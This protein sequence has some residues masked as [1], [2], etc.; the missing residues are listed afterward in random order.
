[1]WISQGEWNE[2]TLKAIDGA[3][4]DM[5]KCLSNPEKIKKWALLENNLSIE[6]GDMT[7]NLKLKRNVVIQ[8]LSGIVDA[9]YGGESPK[10]EIHYGGTAKED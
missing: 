7:A 6:N 3:V 4:E 1:M 8:K 9:L 2:K 10:G 5:N